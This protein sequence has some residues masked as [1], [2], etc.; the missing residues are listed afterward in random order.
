MK[1]ESK[2]PNEYKRRVLIFLAVVLVAIIFW[3]SASIQNAILSSAD[4]ISGFIAE[5]MTLG[6]VIFVI[7]TAL[8]AMVSPLSSA[9]IVPVVITIFGKNETAFLLLFGWLIG[10]ILSYFI[11]SHATATF[12]GKLVPTKRIECY[13]KHISAKTQFALVVLFRLALPS[14]IAGYTLG[15]LRYDFKRYL[16]ATLISEIPFAIISVYAAEA[17]IAREFLPF[18]EMA[19]LG[20]VI[21]V[22]AFYFFKR[23]ISNK[24]K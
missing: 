19:A 24:I 3:S 17:F 2:H 13:R 18:L 21:L 20:T 14:E 9:P 11:G 16:L 22:T 4:L 5:N 15:V 12:L 10:G 7:L 6:V 23:K 8:S 1:E